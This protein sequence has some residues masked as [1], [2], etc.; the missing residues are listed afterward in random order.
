MWYS[1][2]QSGPG[3]GGGA[4]HGTRL[5]ERPPRPPVLD[6]TRNPH[7]RPPQT[8]PPFFPTLRKRGGGG[9]VLIKV[10][11]PLEGP[12]LDTL[13]PGTYPAKSFTKDLS[14]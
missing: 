9:L 6:Y 10:Q 5:N 1:L 4:P 7:P 14:L 11:D 12:T 13:F 2:F 3:R 8:P